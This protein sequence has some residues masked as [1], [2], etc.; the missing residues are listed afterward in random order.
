MPAG[1]VPAAILFGAL[2]QG[3][4]ELAFDMP[5]IT[6]DMIVLI[7]GLVILFAGAMEN[8]FRPA[9]SR[10]FGALSVSPSQTS[11]EGAA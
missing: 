10:M 9:L 6:R 8:L 1:I 5:N 7:Q 11:D 4:A 3:G 2:Y